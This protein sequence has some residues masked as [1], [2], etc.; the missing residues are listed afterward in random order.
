MVKNKLL[1]LMI[2]LI[3]LLVLPLSYAYDNNLTYAEHAGGEEPGVYIKNGVFDS[4]DMKD[5]GKRF[6]LNFTY[7]VYNGDTFKTYARQVSGVAVGIYAQSDTT[8][9]NPLGTF[10]V[11]S[12]TGE[13]LNITIENLTAPTDALWIGEGTGS[14][15]DPREEFDF[16]YVEGLNLTSNIV[17]PGNNS[18]SAYNFN[19]QC[20]FSNNRFDFVQMQL[21]IDSVW[22]QSASI[23]Y[24]E[25][26]VVNFS[27]LI[28]GYKSFSWYCLAVDSE[29][30]NV[31][32]PVQYHIVNQSVQP[33]T[34]GF[35]LPL[36]TNFGEE[37]DIQ[38][39]C[40]AQLA[41]QNSETFDIYGILKWNDCIN[42]ANANFSGEVQIGDKYINVNSENLD[43][44][45]NSSATITFYN[46]SF[47][48]RPIILKDNNI[49]PNNICSLISSWEDV[50]YQETAN[51]S[52]NCVDLNTGSY[53]FEG[54]WSN[55]GNPIDGSWITEGQSST[56]N[57]TLYINYSKPFNIIGANWT[58][59]TGGAPA[60]LE[61]D[62]SIPNSCLNHYTDK[63]SFKIISVRDAGVLGYCMNSSGWEE[64]FNNGVVGPSSD[65][66]Y[67]EAIYWFSNDNLTII[68]VTHFTN[69]SITVNS[70]LTIWDDTDERSE[71]KDKQVYFYADYVDT[72]D[73]TDILGAT[74]NISFSDGSA[75]MSYDGSNGYYEYNRSFS[76]GGIK[77]WSVNCSQGTYEPIYLTDTATIYEWPNITVN[78]PAIGSVNVSRN[79][80]L[81]VTVD[82]V[83]GDVNFTLNLINPDLTYECYQ[84]FANQSESCG[85]LGD[86]SYQ[87][88]TGLSPEMINASLAIDGDWD[89]YAYTNDTG[90]RVLTAYYQIPLF[91]DLDNIIWEVKD[92]AGRVNLTIPRGC[93][94][95]Q[96]EFADL[97]VWTYTF[98]ENYTDWICRNDSSTPILRRTTGTFGRVYEEAV[99]WSIYNTTV[100]L[101]ETNIVSGTD[102]NYT[103]NNL[104]YETTY[105]WSA[106]TD[107]GVHK[108]S[109]PVWNFTT[110]PNNP[111]N[112]TLNNP[113]S[114]SVIDNL[115][116]ILNVTVTDEDGDNMTVSFYHYYWNF[117]SVVFNNN[118]SV[119]AS[120]T[121][122]DIY[123][124]PSGTNFYYPDDAGN[125]L[126]QYNCSIA[127]NLSSCVYGQ[128]IVSQDTFPTAMF[129]S[130]DGLK[131]F[132]LGGS[133]DI[134]QYSCTVAWDI[135]TCSY[136]SVLLATPETWSTGLFF[137]SDGLK[138]YTSD[139]ADVGG[140]KIYQYSCTDAW[141]LSSCSYDSVS[142]DT[143]DESVEGI[144]FKSDG[145]KLYEVGQNSD[146]VYEYDCDNAWDLS[147]CVYNGAFIST[148]AVAPKG[149]FFKPDFSKMYIMGGISKILSEWNFTYESLLYTETNVSSDSTVNYTW[150][151]REYGTTYEWYA[152]ANDS[153]NLVTSDIWN[154]STTPNNPPNI[155]LNNPPN[156]S[157]NNSLNPILNITVTDDGVGG[158]M[159]VEFYNNG[160]YE[161]CYQESSQIENQTGIDGNCNLN[162]IDEIYI[163]SE[164]SV[165]GDNNNFIDGNWGTYTGYN[166][167][168]TWFYI[169]YSKPYEAQ[170]A[171][172]QWIG[173]TGGNIQNVTIPDWC[174]NAYED[175]IVLQFKTFTR[176]KCYN[177]TS[178]IGFGNNPNGYNLWEEAMYWFVPQRLYKEDNVVN[179]SDIVYQ[180]SDR[181]YSTTY[182]WFAIVDDGYNFV[183]SD[184]W[185]FT[186]GLNSQPEIILNN[187]LNGSSLVS[188]N[189]TLS[190]NVTDEEGDNMTVSFYQYGNQ[191]FSDDSF[192][193]GLVDVGS[194]STPT[195]ADF[196]DDGIYELISGGSNTNQF[197]GYY[198][199][200]SSWINNSNLISGITGVSFSTSPEIVDFDQDGNYELIS[201]DINGVFHGFRWNGTQ[202]V[203]NSSLISGLGDIISSSVPSIADFDNDS[204][205]EMIA[206]NNNGDFFSFRWNGT[207][208]VT[209]NSLRVGLSPNPNHGHPAMADFDS[210]GNYEI[211]V[212]NVNGLF[213]GF[214]WNGSRW[215]INSSLSFDLG[216]VGGLAAPTIFDFNQDG[217]YELIAGEQS[218]V[219]N[220]FSWGKNIMEVSNNI[221]SESTIEF[222][223]T[224]LDYNT[225]YNWYVTVS[226][227]FNLVTSDIW[228]FTTHDEPTTYVNYPKN[229]SVDVDNNVDYNIDVHDDAGLYSIEIVFLDGGGI[230]PVS[231]SGT[232]DTFD[233]S[234]LLLSNIDRYW[235]YNITNSYDEHY[236]GPTYKMTMNTTLAPTY[237]DTYFN[238]STTNWTAVPDITNVCQPI[239][240]RGGIGRIQWHGCVD[241]SSADFDSNIF[242]EENHVEVKSENLDSSFNTS[243]DITFYETSYIYG[244]IIYKNNEICTDDICVFKGNGTIFCYQ[245]TANESTVCGGLD[246]G[247]YDFMESYG[248]DGGLWI[249]YT[250]PTNAL[251]G[252]KW[253]VKHGTLSPYNIVIPNQ[254]WEA[255]PNN[256][257]LKIIS[258]GTGVLPTYTQPQCYNGTSWIDIGETEYNPSGGYFTLGNTNKLIDGDWN[259]RLARWVVGE[260][261]SNSMAPEAYIYEEAMNWAIPNGILI[262]VTHFTNYSIGPNAKL[263]IWDSTDSGPIEIN[264]DIKFYAN[265]TDANDSSTLLG[266]VCNITFDNGSIL[267]SYNGSSSLYEY[268]RS[269]ISGGLKNWNVECSVAGYE[270][271]NVAD[272]ANIIYP[273]ASSNS[274]TTS[275]WKMMS[276][277]LDHNSYYDSNVNLENFGLLWQTNIGGIWTDT[278]PVIYDGLLYTSNED[279]LISCLNTTDGGIVWNYSIPV[280]YS[281]VTPAIA[282]DYVIFVVFNTGMMYA[283][284]RTNGDIIWNESIS[285]TGPSSSIAIDNNIIYFASSDENVYAR[286]IT[287]GSEIWTYDT[288]EIL[289][290]GPVIENDRLFVGGIFEDFFALNAT[291]NNP[292]WSFTTC[293]SGSVYSILAV[294]DI[295]YLSDD[296]CG[297]LWAL[298]ATNGN[299]I[300]NYTNDIWT[301]KG[302]LAYR[303]DVVYVA[304]DSNYVYAINATSGNQIWNY[305]ADWK[306]HGISVSDNAV[307]VSGV[308]PSSLYVL[309]ITDGTWIYEYP[310]PTASYSVPAIVDNVV[311]LTP[312]NGNVYAFTYN[313]DY[314]PVTETVTTNPVSSALLNDDIEG[315][316]NVTDVD[317]S[318]LT[319]YYKWYKDGVENVSGSIGSITQG[320]EVNVYNISSNA[321]NIGD[322]WTFSCRGRDSYKYSEWVNATPVS[323]YDKPRIENIRFNPVEPAPTY[324]DITGF[325]NASYSMEANLSYYFIWSK[326]GTEYETNM[327]AFQN[328]T[329]R[330]NLGSDLSAFD[331]AFVNH[332]HDKGSI[333]I[334]EGGSDDVFAST[335][336]FD[337]GYQMVNVDTTQVSATNIYSGGYL[338]ASLIDDNATFVTFIDSA[339]DARMLTTTW[340][341]DFD[342]IGVG[343]GPDL[344]LGG[345][346]YGLDNDVIDNRHAIIVLADGTKG[347]VRLIEWGAT[348]DTLTV[349]GIKDINSQSSYYPQVAS[350]GDRKAIAIWF[351]P[352]TNDILEISLINW[353]SD[354]NTVY[355]PLTTTLEQKPGTGNYD[356]QDLSFD[357]IDNNHLFL[358]YHDGADSVSTG[359]GHYKII[360][361]DSNFTAFNI[362][363]NGT[364]YNSGVDETFFKTLDNNTGVVS[365]FDMSKGET[366]SQI[367][368]WP[369]L[370]E[371]ENYTVFVS[372]AYD[373]NVYSDDLYSLSV[374]YID[375]N[376]FIV[377]RKE[378][379][380]VD[381]YPIVD[382]IEYSDS[383]EQGI[384]VQGPVLDSGYTAEG[385]D[386]TLWCGAEVNP[387]GDDSENITINTPPTI[388]GAIINSSLGLNYSSEDLNGYYTGFS[389]I[390]GQNESNS[391]YDFRV[392]G[393]SIAYL[394]APFEGHSDPYNYAEDYSTSR[395]NGTVASG[396]TFNNTGGPFGDGAYIF[397]GNVPDASTNYIYYENNY[398][399][400]TANSFSITAWFNPRN[401]NHAQHILWQGESGGNGWGS[402]QELHLSI[403]NWYSS[404]THDNELTFYL[405]SGSISNDCLEF[406][407][408]QDNISFTDANNWTFVTVTVY[409][410]GTTP[411][412]SI[413]FNGEWR[414][415]DTGTTAKTAR[416]LWDRG[417]LIGRPSANQYGF[418]GSIGDVKVYS[419]ALSEEQ[420]TNLYNN[421][422]S[423]IS[424]YDTAKDEVWSVCVY[425]NDGLQVNNISA[426][427]GNLTIKDT[428]PIIDAV[429]LNSSTG[430]NI[431]SDNLTST[432]YNVTD[433][434]GEAVKVL[435]NWEVDSTPW[436]V[437]NAPFEGG[438]DNT[439]TPDISG[440]GNN[441]TVALA[442]W[443]KT[444]GFDGFGAYEFDGAGGTDYIQ[445][446]KSACVLENN[447]RTYCGW[448]YVKDYNNGGLI[449][450]CGI[451]NNNQYFAIRTTT[452]F[453][454]YRMDF[455][456]N[457]TDVNLVGSSDSWHHYCIGYN[458]THGRMFYDGIE[459]ASLEVDINTTDDGNF[460][461]GV[462]QG[463][464]LNGTVDEFLAFDY[465]LSDEEIDRLAYNYV[466]EKS[467]QETS[468]GEDWKVCV[469]PTT[470]DANGLEVCSNNLTILSS[471]LYLEVYE[472]AN[473]TRLNQN[474]TFVY[475]ATDDDGVDNCT[476]SINAGDY[477]NTSIISGVNKTTYLDV[478][479][480][481]GTYSWHITCN[482][483]G[484]DVVVSD[485]YYYIYDI[486][487]PNITNLI[488][489]SNLMY[490]EIG[491]TVQLNAT[492]TDRGTID[493]CKLSI[494]DNGTWFNDST[495]NINTPNYAVVDTYFTVR[496]YSTKNNSV[497]YWRMWC[498]NTAGNGNSSYIA[499]FTVKDFTQPM[500]IIGNQSS[501]STN[502]ESVISNHLY[503]LTLDVQF[504]DYN[505]FQA[506]INITCD[507]N[508]S[509]YYW[510]ELDWNGT[511]LINNETVDLGGLDLQKCT[512]WIA[513]SDDHTDI[514]IPEYEVDEISNG[515]KY[516]TENNID[517]EIT[518]KEVSSDY[519]Q[520]TTQKLDDRY[521]IEIDMQDKV[522]MEV[523]NVKTTSPLY[524]RENS[525]YPAHF[526][527]WNYEEEAGNWIDFVEYE[528]D[529]DDFKIDKISDYEADVHAYVYIPADEPLLQNYTIEDEDGKKI[530]N[531]KGKIKSKCKEPKPIK[532]NKHGKCQ[533]LKKPRGVCNV[534]VDDND[535]T[536]LPEYEA[537][538]EKYGKKN[539]KF[540]SI[541]GTNIANATYHFYIGGAINVS[542]ID[543]Y[544]SLP[545]SNFTIDISTIDSYPG[546]DG[547]Q[548]IP[549]SSGWLTNLSNGTYSMTFT[550]P[551]YVNQTQ[552]VL[553]ENSSQ[554]LTFSTYESLLR[555]AIVNVKL[556][557]P[558]TGV[559]LTLTNLDTGFNITLT[560]TT[561][562]TFEWGL[563][564][565][566]YSLHIE[567]ENHVPYDYNFTMEFGQTR[568][569]IAR[570]FFYSNFKLYDE[571]TLEEFN[572]SSPDRI[573]FLLYCPEQTYTTIINS[574]TPKILINCDYIKFK[575]VLDYGTTSYYRTFI[576]DPDEALN[577]NVFL[578]DKKTT[579]DIY[580]SL[581]IDDLLADY[582][583]PAIYVYKII[584]D[585]K[586][587]ITANYVDIE[588]KIGAYLIEN[589]EYIIEIES[590]N[591]PTRVLGT[592]S[593]DLAGE[594]N[595]RLYDIT[596]NPET[597]GSAVLYTLAKYTTNE[598]GNLTTYFVGTYD[599]YDNLTQNVTFNLY[600]DALSTTP[601]FTSYSSDQ[602]IE[603]TVPAAAYLNDTIYAE[604]LV[605]RD[606][607]EFE[608]QRLLNERTKILLGIEFD[609]FFDQNFLNWF[610]IL[611]LGSIALMASIRTANYMSFII[612]GLAGLFIMF[613]WLVPSASVASLV[614]GI[615]G[616]S[617][618]LAII[619][620][621]KR[622]ERN[623]EG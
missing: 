186:T 63:I 384:E 162:Y 86:G 402:Q 502:N 499:N 237:N 563:D 510:S 127:W 596:L 330:Y 194:A 470:G 170:G 178:W 448:F 12:A 473:N 437:I 21:Y 36:T 156:G 457:Y 96:D 387:I 296:N 264:T 415:T 17:Y 197:F 229:N 411:T 513:G 525:N 113:L 214:R 556:E 223:L 57:A 620:T 133:D 451:N 394:N 537:L 549:G 613:G 413:Y 236:V 43:S 555:L 327:Y 370:D 137:K 95:V 30:Y 311:Y 157:V 19:A 345:T 172:M 460:R 42:A 511:T 466:D 61:F 20:N 543:A 220:G 313:Q 191:W 553:V 201:G 401:T 577:V 619:V 343:D 584:N 277:T 416:N 168:H 512:V 10:T 359:V 126:I 51:E 195:I 562:A 140:D 290:G 532:C 351:E 339:R 118:Y 222:N 207:Y 281:K 497:V 247:S 487:P 600:K 575:F 292:L 572:I 64:L 340:D 576:L 88:N 47:N 395:Y 200:G 203:S 331:N 589:H 305:S 422:L 425:P 230:G 2:L 399:L 205:Y 536:E 77:N 427:S 424:K 404:S 419:Y 436:A 597:E 123:F 84:E 406:R 621:L 177:G 432:V 569:L 171:I 603:F 578:I 337:S 213:T 336:T 333:I 310:P 321:T 249:N 276:R 274:L 44:S 488:D 386:W 254:C 595:I 67:E 431:T 11:T 533:K 260:W 307:F 187:P 24:N 485:T 48:Y 522:L 94:I 308:T 109:Y 251:Y 312:T 106:S 381:A 616:L 478:L 540:E 376:H 518:T 28:S 101:E 240:E 405:G 443:N 80:I 438:S 107:N 317:S 149:V 599:D 325:C 4:I 524:Y 221:L 53:S 495:Y 408:D 269:F 592:Y 288:N 368:R 15:T 500:I 498:N 323:V 593:A 403:G 326:N 231:L 181:N 557:T 27:V 363:A 129:F 71:L 286:N 283:F 608:A 183:T 590:D 357:L 393:L 253:L 378:S 444:A 554:S 242:I 93:L 435:Y 362:K 480:D 585:A 385:E 610:L 428:L 22:N 252:S 366:L 410:L 65:R 169:N 542:A 472:P 373:I 295:V 272:T 622:G 474:P 519:E 5:A 579:Q 465:M 530:N 161:Y 31:T 116:P 14:G 196:N 111:S 346:M 150:S 464:E 322:V 202:W 55:T 580:N 215:N 282:D 153:Y 105:Y 244:P 270:T 278:S 514:K 516:T 426:C 279:G 367:V 484:G 515:L 33:N 239:I 255:Y 397:D 60:D 601:F 261:Y 564:A 517:V 163:Y 452:T 234:Y 128:Q 199:N 570:L 259:T 489:N 136:D 606:D 372:D 604:V 442:I 338:T 329:D 3:S 529:Y 265:Y 503:N 309:N 91:A 392:D 433:Y 23:I 501:F 565:G 319:Y 324:E 226:D 420:I 250:K 541:G 476:I 535:I 266:A 50:C 494:N 347:K 189:P 304:S 409:D 552:T 355:Q 158:N 180:W 315:Y 423:T 617:L 25:S 132:E 291:T 440:N 198:W 285:S 206:S 559:N 467:S 108:I 583:N 59:K 407:A 496:P 122:N 507:I 13:W 358:V 446:P 125:D 130:T 45:M 155:T 455:W 217:V 414:A 527:A 210:D 216:D 538:L 34:I 582:D 475:K 612:V 245:E 218:G 258:T 273:P 469:T 335:F 289:V 581:I 32:T 344:V 598:T 167:G 275:E 618:L 224:D 614:T 243:A 29:G 131:M 356:Y 299:E 508:G 528:M 483:V 56:G 354:Y 18:L 78:S 82:N 561:T 102:F 534:N 238:G 454:Q 267:M 418:N 145:L 588:N 481:D 611:L 523:F 587:Q 360:S 246:T 119:I 490:P 567:S 352:S 219:F 509:I 7:S 1:V 190:V 380:W 212:G 417:I 350:I 104:D 141:N 382:M 391:V 383:E 450:G 396:V 558:V 434:D 138:I 9:T 69:Y 548:H 160:S 546:Y 164:D 66:V 52:S 302:S 87:L 369:V 389:D 38:N 328:S 100:L 124:S 271:L 89:T 75:L 184:I 262:N 388:T 298:N 227:S 72:N 348:Y 609:E 461:L 318:T 521:T 148:T 568:E 147:S 607:E 85:A 144:F 374:D 375:S 412:A 361:W 342:N 159:T 365:F 62:V 185:S 188:L 349:K 571:R 76:T 114:G 248:D 468:Y 134:L 112:I 300:W 492:V 121:P 103:L 92:Q 430:Q 232:D 550:H 99:H 429:T 175:K 364:F 120:F 146:R 445:F 208:W 139:K 560:N 70:E 154:F 491:D 398:D 594:K 316:C 115:N 566:N 493:T 615:L 301:D 39:V 284:N 152:T 37:P 90:V 449:R 49:C 390:D 228:E 377:G 173:G 332:I 341:K 379:D 6:Y 174:F 143:Q 623:L 73:S 303:N 605:I 482:G 176:T 83:V 591:Q 41:T 297:T 586:E 334:Y 477:T 58:I 35:Y 447:P 241:A 463:S 16:I 68:D 574:S 545:I 268:N 294:D 192:I 547:Q 453:E 441:G 235:Y 263:E 602:H 135:S 8:G 456:G 40:D 458:G 314:A 544:D 26:G 506:E 182:N 110:I 479:V 573:S 459:V 193:I 520:A 225:T 293:N 320:T 539:F 504:I 98:S 97:E 531:G 74:C 400:Q 204:N 142:I 211:I 117:S 166:A 165:Q 54:S 306:M 151:G 505:M 256:I 280:G 371:G 462:F 439:F 233:T 551:S 486:I 287:D 471:P 79:P 526:V 421:E 257:I 209:N 179:G 81:N 46:A 353:S